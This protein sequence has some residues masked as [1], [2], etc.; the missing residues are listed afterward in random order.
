MNLTRV[1]ITGADD[2][3][4]IPALVDLSAE[5]PFVEWGI[6][7]SKKHEGGYR[8]PSRNWIDRFSHTPAILAANVST[9][10]CGEWVR[11]MFT[12]EIQW[13]DLPSCFPISQRAQ[14]NTHAEKHV[15]TRGMM[16]A[17]SVVSHRI[18]PNGAYDMRE[19][20]FQ[21]DGVNDH[22]SHAV[23][24]YGFKVSA[25]FDTSG[26]A[27]VLPS[28]WPFATTKFWCGYAGGLG[29]H[30]VVDQVAEI[31]KVCDNRPYW[32]DMERRVRTD[33]D[34]ALDMNAVR[35][36]LEAT[37]GLICHK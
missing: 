9:H 16:D 29:P 22:L 24:A 35:A 21:Y 10:I 11:K 33:D 8:F 20:I 31:E 18:L 30:N 23:K 26:G 3:T 13:V 17:L 4:S 15:S 2:S 7:V 6:L 27:G 14:I 12:G 1:T 28:R 32:I 36:V 34:S 37:K 25:L 19:F 5:F